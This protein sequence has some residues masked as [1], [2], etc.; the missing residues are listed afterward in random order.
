MGSLILW[1]VQV[2]LEIVI[3]RLLSLPLSTRLALWLLTSLAL[4]CILPTQVPKRFATS[5]ILHSMYTLVLALEHKVLSTLITGQLLSAIR[6]VW[7]NSPVGTV[8]T[9]QNREIPMCAIIMQATV[10]FPSFLISPHSSPHSHAS[11][12]PAYIYSA[13][14]TI[15]STSWRTGAFASSTIAFRLSRR[16]PSL[17]TPSHHCFV[18]LPV[19]SWP[20]QQHHFS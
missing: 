9:L 19:K 7:L 1:L 18:A 2:L 15:G 10:S 8:S 13:F 16:N 6:G 20:C 3:M 11:G 17:F 5:R 14:G 12:C 4:C